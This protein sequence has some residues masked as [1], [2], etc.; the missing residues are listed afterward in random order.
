MKASVQSK[1]RLAPILLWQ[2]RLAGIATTLETD[3]CNAARK[4][5]KLFIE[6]IHEV[7]KEEG[8]DD[9]E[10]LVYEAGECTY[11]LYIYYVELYT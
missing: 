8:L 4:F 6:A 5:R 1:V 2:H 7:A 11:I 3:T 10:I 9:G